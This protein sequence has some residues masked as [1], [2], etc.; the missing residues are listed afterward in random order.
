[1]SCMDVQ[2][3]KEPFRGRAYPVWSDARPSVPPRSRLYH[4]APIAV[5]TWQ[6][7]SLTSYVT[8]LAAAHAIT[9]QWLLQAI[10]PEL[11]LPKYVNSQKMVLSSDSSSPALRLDG[12]DQFSRA[13]VSAL[14][15]LT[16]HDD[17]LG[18]TMGAWK[19][20]LGRSE[21]VRKQRTWCPYCFEQQR[22]KGNVVYAPLF[23]SLAD[24]KWCDEHAAPLEMRCPSCDREANGLHVQAIMGHCPWCRTWL[25][26]QVADRASKRRHD[27]TQHVMKQRNALIKELIARSNEV[28][29]ESHSSCFVAN[30]DAIIAQHARGVR[31]RLALALGWPPTVLQGW[32]YSGRRPQLNLVIDLSIRLRVS[33][34][35]LLAGSI[36]I[37]PETAAGL[38]AAAASAYRSNFTRSEI[39][40]EYQRRELS[41]ILNAPERPAA[42]RA[43]AR[44]LGCAQSNLYRHHR[45]LCFQITDRRRAED[46]RRDQARDPKRGPG[47]LRR[48]GSAIDEVLRGFLDANPPLSANQIATACELHTATLQHYH[49]ELMRQLADRYRKYFRERTKRIVRPILE[50]AVVEDPAPSLR[51]VHRRVSAATGCRN[52]TVAYRHYP[53]LCREIAARGMKLRNDRATERNRAMRERIESAIHAIKQSGGVP[54]LTSVV[55]LACEEASDRFRASV[56][57]REMMR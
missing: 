23:W 17:L 54:T 14:E 36:R 44:E 50:A 41:R 48:D 15:V 42:I 31:R 22:R 24:A 33:P 12:S 56:L 6:V 45:D 52:T 26:R 19:G 34:V 29:A 8:R 16:M 51:E 25:G 30:L 46:P 32:K 39:D 40:H 3:T 5:G 4:L 28:S 35:D 49:G 53:T 38:A 18:L 7:E 13:V 27:Q 43:I 2:P 9:P 47:G 55:A 21:L 37:D 11:G 10:K 57:Y 1:M 20:I